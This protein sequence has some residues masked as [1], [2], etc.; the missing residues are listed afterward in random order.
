MITYTVPNNSEVVLEIYNSIGQK[1]AELFS[2]IRS[3]GVYSLSWNAV[4]FRGGTY[5][6]KFTPFTKQK[7]YS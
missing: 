3:A 1:V 4:G 7:K 5:F 2:G 6:T